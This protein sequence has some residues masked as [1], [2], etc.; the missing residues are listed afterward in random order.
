[1]A[2]I[3]ALAQTLSRLVFSTFSILPRRGSTAWFSRQRAILA[4]PPAESPSTMKSSQSFGMRPEQ[5]ASLP[6]RDRPARAV[7]RRAIS[8]ALLAAALAFLARTALLMMAL[9]ASGFCSRNRVIFVYTRWSITGRALL[10]PSFCLVCPSNC[11]SF[12]R[13]LMTAVMPSDSSSREM[14][15]SDSFNMPCFLA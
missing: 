5:S 14:D 7:F 3:S 12:R 4:E 15:G 11:G 8:L 9:A 6:G 10:L 2:L 13:T 1:M